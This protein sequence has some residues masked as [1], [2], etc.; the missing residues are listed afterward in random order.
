MIKGI[1]TDYGIQILNSELKE[2]VQNYILIGKENPKDL[3]L[4]NLIAKENILFNEIE[5]FIFH[6]NV[7]EVCYFDENGILTYEINLSNIDTDKYMYA[8]LLIDSNN[9]IVASLPT[10]Q[11]VLMEGVGGLITIKLPIQGEVNEVVFVNSDYISREEFEVLKE[12]LKP[13]K[14]DIPALVEEITPL[15]QNKKDIN[16]RI[17]NKLDSMINAVRFLLLCYD[18][19]QRDN[20]KIGE[21]K[22]FYRNSLPPFFKPLGSLLSI[23]KYPKAYIYF[24]NTNLDLQENCPMGYFKLPKPCIYSKGVNNSSSV[25]K[26]NQSGLPNITGG[27]Y[28]ISET[29]NVSGYTS[30]AF[31]KLGGYGGD[32]TPNATDWSNSSGVDFNASRSSNIYGRAKNVEVEHNCLL[33]GI[34]VGK[35]LD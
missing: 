3:I 1:P 11:V 26:S 21:Y 22:L 30:G 28:I 27:M 20:S 10:P 34:Y 18:N 9:K 14:V 35:S 17:M 6:R 5:E 24:K 16:S 32:G 29:W 7:I 8:I 12:S 19:I 31:S 15:I 23:Y 13:P 2:Q 33:E 25:G 4:E